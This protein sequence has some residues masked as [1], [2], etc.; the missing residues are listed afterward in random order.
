[1]T[2]RSWH[3]RTL[4]PPPSLRLAVFHILKLL[5]LHL[6]LLPHVHLIILLI[7]LR[8]RLDISTASPSTPTPGT[9]PSSSIRWWYSILREAC[10]ATRTR[11]V[12]K[13]PSVT[14]TKR[15]QHKHSTKQK[16]KNHT[17]DFGF[18]FP[19]C[20]NPVRKTKSRLLQ[21]R[22]KKTVQLTCMHR[23]IELTFNLMFIKGRNAVL[24]SNKTPILVGFL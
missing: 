21:C 1:M 17:G 23:E 11:W 9:T 10:P 8:L 5:L 14:C 3:H 19:D 24:L 18:Y 16:I 15:N 2:S 7:M 20:N 13:E 4:P 6:L 22:R 12:Q